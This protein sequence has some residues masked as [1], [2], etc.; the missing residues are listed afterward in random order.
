G[1]RRP[2]SRE[3]EP[4]TVDHIEDR[5]V[6]RRC[7]ERKEMSSRRGEAPHCG[8]VQIQDDLFVTA[9]HARGEWAWNG[10]R[11][12]HVTGRSSAVRRDETAVLHLVY[13]VAERDPAGRPSLIHTFVKKL[14]RLSD[15]I[16]LDVPVES[17]QE[18]RVRTG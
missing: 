5:A 3:I 13:L 11:Q 16:R 6:G 4:A 1:Q 9:Q 17:L 18:K 15:A 2:A 14:R 12:D 10:R 7:G 8:R